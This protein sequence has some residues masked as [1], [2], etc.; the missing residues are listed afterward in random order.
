MK[1]KQFQ[2]EIRELDLFQR[3]GKQNN[4]NKITM[5]KK[6]AKKLWTS[7]MKKIITEDMDR[8]LSVGP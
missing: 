6:K 7:N 3:S 1:E 5:K 8:S 2:Y 4:T